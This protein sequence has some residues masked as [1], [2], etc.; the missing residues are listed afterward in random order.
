ML[1]TIYNPQE[2][3]MDYISEMKALHIRFDI[4]TEQKA[5][6]IMQT[7][8]SYYQL[9]EYSQ[10]F[11]QYEKT[12]QKGMFIHLDFAQLYFLAVIDDSVRLLIL[13]QFLD[14]ER[15]LKLYLI[16][17][18]NQDQAL[19]LCPVKEYYEQ[20]Q[21]Y[22]IN[23]YTDSR[24]DTVHAKYPYLSLS[25]MSISQ[26]LDI[27]QFGTL[28]RF[29]TFCMNHYFSFPA[30]GKNTLKEC[31]LSV[32]HLRNASAHNNAILSNLKNRITD[33]NNHYAASE[34]KNFLKSSGINQKT[35]STNM[36]RTVTRDFCNFFYLYNTFATHPSI[37]STCARWSVFFQN[38][39]LQYGTYFSKNELLISAFTFMQKVN[40]IYLDSIS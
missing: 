9:M 17:F 2:I 35:L 36:T 40:T 31:L 14:L 22:I 4:I 23:V 16:N 18:F 28:E 5:A 11:E 30:E 3:I 13:N 12:S 38:V 15:M 24:N 34:V 20:D 10:L 8:Y 32:R 21:A 6:Q 26:F 7:E 25:E 1:F 33:D 37:K 29:F 39:Y 27:I 19:S